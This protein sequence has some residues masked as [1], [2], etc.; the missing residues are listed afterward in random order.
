VFE[1]PPMVL[2]P[3]PVTYH[4]NKPTPQPIKEKPIL[5]D[6]TKIIVDD[7]LVDDQPTEFPDDPIDI[8]I[9]YGDD[10]R[11]ETSVDTFIFVENMPEPEGGYEAF[12]KLLSK[13]MKY[14]TKAKTRNTEGRVFVEFV[15]NKEGMPVNMK[16]LKGI[17]NGCDEEAMRVLRLAKWNAGKQRGRQVSVKMVMPIY[18]KLE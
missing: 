3:V 1:D 4:E 9:N 15:V 17:G 2:Y 11:I 12:Y 16:V 13:N 6:P 14:P 18:F 7:N 10:D 5:I 8:S